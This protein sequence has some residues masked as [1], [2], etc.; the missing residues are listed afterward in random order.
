MSGFLALLGL[1]GGAVAPALLADLTERMAFRGPDGQHTWHDG[2]IGLSH[3]LLATT[4]EAVRE[5][6]P[7]SL[8]GE[9]RL[10]GAIRLDGRD[11][12]RAA[13]L[14]AGCQPAAD[15]TDPDLLLHAYTAWG[16]GCLDRIIGDFAFVLWDGRR[17][18]L[19]AARDHFGVAQLFWARVGDILILG[20]TLQAFLA[21]PG[22]SDEL[23]EAAVSDWAVFG[24]YLDSEAT[25]YRQ[26]HRV[27]HGQKLTLD[28]GAFRIAPYWTPVD[29]EDWTR[30]RRDE[31]YAE[32]FLHL[33]DLAVAD[34]LR[35][36]RAGCHLSGGLD[37]S[38]IAASASLVQD[39]RGGPR[40]LRVYT[41]MNRGLAMD[42][43]GEYAALVARRYGLVHEFFYNEDMMAQAPEATPAW[44]PP[45]PGPVFGLQCDSPLTRTA[46]F[47]RNMLAGFGGDA[48][49]ERPAF[50]WGGI[51]GA[52]RTGEFRWLLQAGRQRL[53][54]AMRPA[55]A[56]WR[57]PGW[58]EAKRAE[59]L[60]D[61]LRRSLAQGS[62]RDRLGLFQAPLWRA[63][64]A[65]SDAGYHGLPVVTSFPFFDRRLFDFMAAV[66]PGSRGWD[67][68]LLRQAMVSRLPAE[69]LSRPKTP[70]PGN[71]YLELKKSAGIAAW[72]WSLLRDPAVL[73]WLD[74]TW[75]K[76]LESM[77]RAE[78][79]EAWCRPRMPPLELAYWLAWRRMSQLA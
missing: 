70:L 52:L 23:D 53:R 79:A 14:G 24:M 34:R 3:A 42:Q 4:F 55:A 28:D 2:V 46:S 29:S 59:P 39:R 15:A 74:P 26:I 12:L 31:D 10:T 63:I 68:P 35:T 44:L 19:L 40:D 76:R 16:D 20:N 41:L 7:A 58:L 17:R 75:S 21:Y 49:L 65:W 69:L 5:Q 22:I 71:P 60:A 11:D 45:E 47:A 30:P 27:G 43:E 54:H 57:P 18:R 36:D 66:P 51:P 73:P 25:G 9:V 37:S 67:K 33:F 62:R 6:Q 56:N 32:E 1:D 50:T 48:L 61:R 72:E 8:D 38:A 78:Q 77:P 64:F 13:L